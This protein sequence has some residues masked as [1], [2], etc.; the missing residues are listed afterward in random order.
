MQSCFIYALI[1]GCDLH[2]EIIVHLI[3]PSIT[4]TTAALFV[5]SALS[6]KR[7]IVL[8]FLYLLGS[9]LYFIYGFQ[10]EVLEIIFWNGI[11]I[12]IN[13]VRIGLYFLEIKPWFIN[14]TD[15]QLYNSFFKQFMLPGHFRK[16]IKLAEKIIYRDTIIL[17]EDVYNKELYF[18]IRKQ[19]QLLVRAEH[20][21]GK[22]YEHN[23]FGEMSF[24]KG[25]KTNA[26]IQIIGE[27]TCYHWSEENLQI[28]KKNYPNIFS[29]LILILSHDLIQK[30]N[31]SQT[32]PV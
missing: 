8:R 12:L 19:G 28:L 4:Y 31:L 1:E 11:N 30:L 20:Y 27:A 15:L 29:T 13:S 10:I 32:C 26:S 22:L 21:S 14:P 25:Q 9:I 16:I 17:K 24:L 2:H 3:Y 18:V 7:I 6:V 23:F 5:L